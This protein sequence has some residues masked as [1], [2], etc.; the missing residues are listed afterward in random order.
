[1]PSVLIVDDNAEN[2]YFL[3]MLLKGNGFA[4]RSA[5]QGAQALESALQEPPDLIVSD[6]LMPVMDGYTLCRQWRAH[7]RLQGIPF[8]FYTATYT[9]KKDESLALSLGADRFVIKPQEPEALMAII[10][11]V[12]A[13]YR[14]G[15]QRAAAGTARGEGELLK[16]YNE[17]LFQKLE[18]KMA[19]LERANQELRESA[20]HFRQFLMECPIPIAVSGP[21]GTIE[22]VNNWYQKTIGYTLSD[23]PNIEAWW[24]RAYPDPGYRAEVVRSWQAATEQALRDGGVVRGADEYRVTCKDGTVRTMEIYGAPI[25]NRLLVI[26]N[27]ITERK[28]ADDEIRRLAAMLEQR[29]SDRTAQLEET[30]KEL[31]AFSYSVSHDLRAPLRAIEGFS[32]VVVEEYG[33]R[34]DDEGRRLLGMIRSSATRMSRLIDD[35]LAFSRTGRA[36]MKR[37]RL[38]MRGLALSVIEEVVADPGARARIDFTVGP[39]PEVD[40]DGALIRQVWV[41]L[42]SNAVKFSS[43]R[44]RPR[45][46][47]Y[48]GLEEHQGV[49]HVRDNGSG[50]DMQFINK[51]FRVFQ[52]LHAADQ[53]EGTGIGLALAQ[54]IVARHGGCIWAEAEVGKGATF[55]FALPTAP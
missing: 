30:N 23:L 33:E 52:R 50:F 5:P 11:E 47:I 20:A 31:E 19:D 24:Q 54:R 25:A 44:P 38:D 37:S 21:D 6:I 28:R 8:I 14:S 40:G 46:E 39:L 36:E 34:L 53:Y 17:V 4:V 51:L 22:L 16:D 7:E 1:M 12:L 35:L 43:Q 48:G 13:E 26:L 42:I 41:N 27:D 15:T 18:K 3:E 2:L 29:V 45:I 32:G 9:D 10:R 49:Y 55:S